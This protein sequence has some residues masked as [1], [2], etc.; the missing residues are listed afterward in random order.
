MGQAMGSRHTQDWPCFSAEGG[1][2]GRRIPSTLHLPLPYLCL[3]LLLM[4]ATI[5]HNA[6]AN[7]W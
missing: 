4:P 1:R 3:P 6:V 7:P 5:L 2:V